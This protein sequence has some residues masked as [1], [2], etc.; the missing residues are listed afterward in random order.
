[1]ALFTGLQQLCTFNIVA[2]P[3]F[4]HRLSNVW[5]ASYTISAPIFVDVPYWPLY[6][7]DKIISCVVPGSSQWFF[8]FGEEIVIAWTR[9]KTTTLVG[10]EPYHSSWQCESHRC[11]HRPL[12]PLAKGDSGIS[13][14][15]T[16]WVHAITISSPKWKNHCEE[17]GATQ[18]MNLSIL[19]YRT[20]N[21]EHQQRWTRWWC[22]TPSKHLAKGDK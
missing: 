13:T 11:C 2:P 19:I 17:P 22:T 16:R 4:Y 18:E 6:S 21:T 9:E 1:M 10:T 8:H 7:T 5:K 14:V 20:V 15:L 12:A 3:S